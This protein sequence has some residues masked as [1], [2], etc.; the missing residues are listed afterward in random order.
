MGHPEPTDTF[1]PP[2]STGSLDDVEGWMTKVGALSGTSYLDEPWILTVDNL[3]VENNV[4]VT[5]SM[6]GADPDLYGFTPIESTQD[7][8][9]SM[10]DL[11]ITGQ[12]GGQSQ[13]KEAISVAASATLAASSVG[14]GYLNIA[15]NR[16]TGLAYATS[17]MFF[18]YSNLPSEPVINIKRSS[19]N[20]EFSK[21]TVQ[22]PFV[23][24]ESEAVGLI[25]KFGADPSLTRGET[26]DGG[27][28]IVDALNQSI[29]KMAE[30]LVTS[31]AVSEKT[32]P[33]TP[34]LKIRVQDI[35]LIEGGPRRDTAP[36]GDP[37]ATDAPGELIDPY[38]GALP[39]DSDSPDGATFTRE[40]GATPRGDSDY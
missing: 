33:R 17:K 30:T 21:Y 11:G 9:M 18:H 35:S 7:P 40:M 13:Q 2:E 23:Y 6:I 34:P 8:R 32:F 5:N 37:S 29:A 31:Y 14:I 25:S 24:S 28:V 19:F 16:E 39:I 38:T 36:T 3:E 10:E 4:L 12:S 20:E 22:N 26:A 27:T 1:V 15:T